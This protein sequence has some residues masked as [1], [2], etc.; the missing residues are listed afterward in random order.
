MDNITRIKNL[1]E[2]AYKELFGI[3][4][5]TF[6]AALAV[7][8]REYAQLHKKGGRP[9]RLTVLDKWIATL[10]YCHDYRTMVNIAF[11]YDVS[12]SRISDAVRWVEQTLVKD[13]SFSLP[14]KRELVKDDTEIIV[15]IAD[16]TERPTERP[17][18]KQKKLYSGKKK[19][20]TIKDLIIIDG[21]T[22]RII[23]VYEDKGSVH[24]FEMYKRSKVHINDVITLFADKGFQGVADLH[25][26]SLTPF[27]K[28]KGGSLTDEQ[29]K[30]NRWISRFRILIENV[31]R[32]IKRFKMFSY[33][34]RSKQ[35]KHLMRL[36]LVCGLINCE[37]GF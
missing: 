1:K 17:K 34:Y 14:S 22:G 32:L 20:H 29:K 7:L 6:D 25:W 5:P 21:M 8:E 36:M 9:S 2:P 12:K 18:K 13:G 15:V 16:V 10:S 33:R 19:Q 27:K 35:M 3:S 28:P 4:K 23:C 26:N 31:N 24:D 11:D 30:T 37:L